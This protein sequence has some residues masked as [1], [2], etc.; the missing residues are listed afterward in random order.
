MWRIL[1]GHG[2][3]EDEGQ[4]ERSGKED[5]RKEG[6]CPEASSQGAPREEEEDAGAKG[7][8][9]AACRGEEGKEE[10]SGREEIAY[11]V[12]EGARE[13]GLREEG[14]C[15]E[16]ACEEGACEEGACEEGAGREEGACSEEGL[17]GQGTEGGSRAATRRRGSPR[18]EVRSR[19]ARHERG[20]RDGRKELSRGAPIRRD[21]LVEELG[22][23]FVAEATSAE[24]E[25]EQVLDQEVPEDRGGPF[26]ETTAE[27]EFAYGTDASNPKGAKREP[28]PTT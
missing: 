11:G 2:E 16:G 8:C 13:E 28:F 15:E 21:D 7:C 26:V 27:D 20:P 22:E 24:H 12:E 19:P 4:E 17:R 10:S 18:P 9:E 5:P 14:A 1:S 3:E 6:R 23:E 25:A